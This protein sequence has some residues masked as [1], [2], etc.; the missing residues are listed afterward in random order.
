[1]PSA[2]FSAKSA[3]TSHILIT[4]AALELM[5]KIKIDACRTASG[6]Q[7]RLRGVFTN[8]EIRKYIKYCRELGKA[9]GTRQ[10]PQRALEDNINGR[11][12][13]HASV[14]E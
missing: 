6:T 14:G 9:L 11:I 12:F 5:T 10:V 4:I 13:D 3:G 2:N 7:G 8:Q 1:L